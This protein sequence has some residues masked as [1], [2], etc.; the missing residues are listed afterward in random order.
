[1]KDSDKEYWQQLNNAY[2]Q[3]A[4]QFD[5]QIL[6]FSSGA[7]GLS[8]A[9]IKD[10]VVLS[11]STHKGLLITSWSFFGTVILLSIISHYTSLRAINKRIENL[12]SKD[13]KQTKRLNSVTQNLN[14]LMILLLAAGLILLTVFIGI[15]I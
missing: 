11:I 1:M 14:I 12:N 13:D 8:F 4:S 3:S 2:I 9:F 6:F 5:K 10:I 7:F 15:N